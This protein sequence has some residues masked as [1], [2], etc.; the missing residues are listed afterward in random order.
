MEWP[1]VEVVKVED[2]NRYNYYGTDSSLAREE[3][4]Q[5]LTWELVTKEIY[6]R[7]AKAAIS[8]IMVDH[9]A[10]GM[11]AKVHAFLRQLEEADSIE[12]WNTHYRN[13]A[14]SFT[15]LMAGASPPARTLEMCRGGLDAVHDILKYRLPDEAET[16]DT[17]SGRRKMRRRKS[18]ADTVLP[19]RDAFVLCQ[20]FPKLPT[21][22][23]SGTRAPDLSYRYGL[24]T[25]TPDSNDAYASEKNGVPA[26]T[27]GNNNNNNNNNDDNGKNH[28]NHEH[29]SPTMA[30]YGNDACKHVSKLREV[31]QLE[32]SAASLASH[33][34]TNYELV[35]SLADKTFVVL[36]CDHPLSPAKSLLRIPGVTVLGIPSSRKGLDELLEYIAYNAPDDTSFVYPEHNNNNNEMDTN[37]VLSRGPQVAQWILDN[38]QALYD[39][40]EVDKHLSS[41]HRKRAG[42]ELVLVP[43]PLPSPTLNK[44]DP[45]DPSNAV[46]TRVRESAIRWAAAIDLI[47]QRVLR[48]RSDN[49]RCSVWS[50]QSSTTCM[51][52]PAASTTKS[53]ELLQS[54]PFHE[55]YLHKLSMGT[56][57]KPTIEDTNTTSGEDDPED[58][59][60]SPSSHDYAIVNGILTNEGPHHM[61]AEHIRLWRAI[62]THFADEYQGYG[63]GYDD[64]DSDSDMDDD[65]DDDPT[66]RRDVYVFAPHVPL[67]RSATDS[68]LVSKENAK[69]L[70]DPLRIF[71]AGAVASL[72]AAIGIAGLTDPIV[73]RPMPMVLTSGEEETTPFA[74]FWYGS[75]HGGI[76]NCPYTLESVS[77]TIGYVLGKAYEYYQYYAAGNGAAGN[78]PSTASTTD[79]K[80]VDAVPS[81]DVDLPDIVQQRLEMYA[82]QNM[83]V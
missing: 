76:W 57:L 11:E 35:P 28:H 29:G 21:K 40:D 43:M 80:I 2:Q 24:L 48:A 67:S 52:V 55:P 4:L 12:K 20:S 38:T 33:T 41:Y 6:A 65:D 45:S 64:D 79:A 1:S 49:V 56:L 3:F 15:E 13:C 16:E 53:T 59:S 36:G 81:K 23:V 22:S 83:N 9:E 17:T 82:G 60:P 74:M 27:R 31:G 77:G 70:D 69:L 58:S 78:D 61:L 71:D 18:N 44:E 25:S 37:I 51:V 30:L 42:S 7:A 14:R 32:T 68:E 5:N 26:A 50:Y 62:V 10:S 46:S 54:R 72:L 19:A 34:L 63:A 47:V 66:S 8:N 75:F 39:D 73:N